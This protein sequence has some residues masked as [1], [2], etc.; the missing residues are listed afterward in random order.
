[1]NA[2]GAE[3]E[4]TTGGTSGDFENI[5]RRAV[6]MRMAQGSQGVGDFVAGKS[7]RT[8]VLEHR[9]FY[10]SEPVVE[11]GAALV[12]KGMGVDPHRYCQ[13]MMNA[14]IYEQP[15][16]VEI[17]FPS[18]FRRNY[19]AEHFGQMI[20]QYYPKPVKLTYSPSAWRMMTEKA[21]C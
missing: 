10:M 17:T 2:Y 8:G 1:M 5:L 16:G 13:A 11:L 6:A 12:A 4:A 3:A 14:E 18:G 9:N 20:R 15:Q 19:A 7:V 21:A